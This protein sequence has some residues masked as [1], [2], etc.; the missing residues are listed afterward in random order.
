M[1]LTIRPSVDARVCA[2]KY[3]EARDRCDK[4]PITDRNLY[5]KL[6]M[7]RYQWA[8]MLAESIAPAM[9]DR[10]AES[11]FRAVFRPSSRPGP[12]EAERG[13]DRELEDRTAAQDALHQLPGV[14]TVAPRTRDT[15]PAPVDER[16]ELANCDR[17]STVIREG[18]EHVHENTCFF[19]ISC[20]K[21][22]DAEDDR[23]R[24]AGGVR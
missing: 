14:G 19:C 23:R 2:E 9:V 1:A 22:L 13:D 7:D 15:L 16:R 5:A 20:T 17:C 8:L 4:V 12:I 6:T 10:S 18:D 24:A 3:I 11:P 21:A